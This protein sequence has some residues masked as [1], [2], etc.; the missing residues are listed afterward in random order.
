MLNRGRRGAE[1]YTHAADTYIWNHLTWLNVY[2]LFAMNTVANKNTRKTSLF[3]F[4]LG[5]FGSVI[6]TITFDCSKTLNK[7]SPAN[8]WDL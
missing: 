2:Y 4:I 7:V 5:Y 1:V 3:Q 8:E 6:S